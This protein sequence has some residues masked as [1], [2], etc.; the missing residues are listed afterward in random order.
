MVI[1]LFFFSLLFI[2]IVAVAMLAPSFRWLAIVLISVLLY[3][4]SFYVWFALQY[5]GMVRV[6]E[7]LNVYPHELLGTSLGELAF[8]GPPM[9]PSLILLFYYFVMRKFNR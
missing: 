7:I 8:F 4:P 3:F 2:V 1:I 9:L 5:F 6:E